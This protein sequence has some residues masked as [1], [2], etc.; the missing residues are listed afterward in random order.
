LLDALMTHSRDTEPSAGQL[1][2]IVEETIAVNEPMTTQQFAELR[3]RLQQRVRELSDE[4]FAALK[5]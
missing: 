4:D 3:E 2:H 1:L 5:R